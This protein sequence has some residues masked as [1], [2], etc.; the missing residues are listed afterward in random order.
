MNEQGKSDERVVPRKPSNKGPAN[1]GSAE[2]VEERRSAKGNPERQNSIWT[3]SQEGLQH[4][5]QRI[6]RVA[7]GDRKA[8][9][10]A[11]WH[12]VYDVDRLRQAYFRLKRRAAPGM[13]KVTWQ[14]Y[15]KALEGNLLDLSGRLKRG[16]YRAKPVRRVGIPKADGRQRLIGIPALED[17]IVQG[18]TGEVL[19]AVY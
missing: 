6:R 18:A 16:A 7:E 1:A 2:G 15:G 9:F 5:L 10:T 19:N 17:K 11:L 12:H 14:D 8:R 3:Q 13:D 4:A